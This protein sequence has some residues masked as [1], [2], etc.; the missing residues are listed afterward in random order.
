MARRF[1]RRPDFV[2][3]MKMV[4]YYLSA[5]QLKELTE[6]GRV[7]RIAVPL[8]DD[9]AADG[10][11]LAY[12]QAVIAVEN[13]RWITAAEITE[14]PVTVHVGTPG[15]GLQGLLGSIV[16]DDM[17][18][19]PNLVVRVV[20]IVCEVSALRRPRAASRTQWPAYVEIDGRRYGE[21]TGS[22][23]STE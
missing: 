13:P 17:D 8:P 9:W 14:L 7:L 10:D 12:C 3:E 11:P 20:A 6:R 5:R 18:P 1:P 4:R 16:H 2:W 19:R 21:E 23:R 15:P 22:T